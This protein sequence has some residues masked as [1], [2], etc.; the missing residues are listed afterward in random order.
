MACCVHGGLYHN[1]SVHACCH[2]N[3]IINSAQSTLISEVYIKSSECMEATKAVAR[4]R[5]VII[6]KN[7]DELINGINSHKQTIGTKNIGM[8]E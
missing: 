3:I 5:Y 8:H 4:G 7:N 1:S 6:W 2:A